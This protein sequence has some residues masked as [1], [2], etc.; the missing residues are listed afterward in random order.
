MI[1]KRLRDHALGQNDM[2]TTQIKAA[3]IILRK[4]MPDLKAV[5]HSGEISHAHQMSD[6]ELDRRI[7]ELSA[8]VGAAVA[9]GGAT[10]AH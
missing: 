6:A 8:Q 5:E 4:A 3:E 2:T 1:A 7:A 10:K 9:A